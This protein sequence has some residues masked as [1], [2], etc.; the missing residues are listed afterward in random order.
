MLAPYAVRCF[1]YI[2]SIDSVAELCNIL[3]RVFRNCLKKPNRYLSPLCA[4]L[5]WDSF[6]ISSQKFSVRSDDR[7]H[8]DDLQTLTQTVMY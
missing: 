2:E 1:V 3:R 8:D 6:Q 4:V 5:V 7:H